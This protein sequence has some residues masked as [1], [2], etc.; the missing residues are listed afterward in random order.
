MNPLFVKVKVLETEIQQTPVAAEPPYKRDP[1]NPALMKLST[2]L[3]SC[4]MGEKP[5]SCLW[6]L[7]P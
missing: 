5:P 6:M 4:W 7:L 1:R 3:R 2:L